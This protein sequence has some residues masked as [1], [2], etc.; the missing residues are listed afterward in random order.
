MGMSIKGPIT[1]NTV[2]FALINF[3]FWGFLGAQALTTL[4]FGVQATMKSSYWGTPYLNFGN[5]PTV[6]IHSVIPGTVGN[7]G[8]FAF[9]SA[10]VASAMSMAVL[11]LVGW[12]ISRIFTNRNVMIA[13]AGFGNGIC[14]LIL[15]TSGMAYN[16]TSVPGYIINVIGQILLYMG[17]CQWMMANGE[18]KSNPYQSLALSGYGGIIISVVMGAFWMYNGMIG[19]YSSYTWSFIFSTCVIFMFAIGGLLLTKKVKAAPTQTPTQTTEA[20]QV[21]H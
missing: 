12:G 1:R 18:Y 2:A 5:L 9:F 15:I 4:N 20:G 14:S 21:K 11:F 19:P 10:A 13:I 6:I 3:A 8:D 7:V 17:L 16:L